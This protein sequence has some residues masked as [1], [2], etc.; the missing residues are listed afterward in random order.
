MWSENSIQTIK[1]DQVL[2][3][4]GNNH[5]L[6]KMLAVD[7]DFLAQRIE[8][9]NLYVDKAIYTEGDEIEFIYFPIDSLM[10]LSVLEDGA[11]VEISMVGREGVAGISAI[12]GSGATRLWVCISIGGPAIRL[13][14]Q[15]LQ[16]LFQRTMKS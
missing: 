13:P 4:A 5:L 1:R 7:S 12:P 10:S 3:Y 6:A 15:A 8:V 16:H 9:V 14:A 2:G 11:T